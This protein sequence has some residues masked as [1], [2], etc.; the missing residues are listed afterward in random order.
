MLCVAMGLNGQD[1]KNKSK[2]M[3]SQ[4]FR[5]CTKCKRND[6]VG[7]KEGV[8]EE[9]KASLKEGTL[10]SCTVVSEDGGLV[11]PPSEKKEE[12]M[13]TGLAGVIGLATSTK[14]CLSNK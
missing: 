12:N 11:L 2:A 8:G 9:Y 5:C 3:Y 1:Q 7:R 10:L 13:T 4:K 14:P 6:V